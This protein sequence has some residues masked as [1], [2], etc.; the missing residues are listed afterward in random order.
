MY[1]HIITCETVT[2]L[3]SAVYSTLVSANITEEPKREIDHRLYLILG[4]SPP[5]KN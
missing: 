2:D 3:P 1:N 4:T 5:R